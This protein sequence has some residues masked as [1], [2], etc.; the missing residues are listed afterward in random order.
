MALLS[1]PINSDGATRAVFSA[2]E[3]PRYVWR[4]IPGVAIEQRL[5]PDLVA[6]VIAAHSD[7]IVMSTRAS[8]DG[9]SLFTT[10][11]HYR[12]RASVWE[13]LLGALKMR[14]N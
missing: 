11:A 2:L 1:V 14:I 8:R 6:E 4:T 9:Q 13:K 7:V 12:V 3:S 5:D 10:R